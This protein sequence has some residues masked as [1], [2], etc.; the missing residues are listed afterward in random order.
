[1]VK[2]IMVVDDNPDV[3]FSIKNGLEGIGD[4]SYEIIGADSG[5]QC[6]ELLSSDQIP[7]VILL[8]IMMPEMSGW[9]VFKQLWSN[10]DW[11]KI[12]IAFLS[13]KTDNFSKGFGKILA[14]MYIEK[15]FEIKDL[16]DKIESIL[17][18]PVEVSEAKEKIIEDI[19]NKII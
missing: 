18:N 19:L 8:D 4:D 17:E 11:K 16:K 10:E 1:M 15:P 6:I 13:A 5:K 2:K 14:K 12:P 9:D 3:I 7:D